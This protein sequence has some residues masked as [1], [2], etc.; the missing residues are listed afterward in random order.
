MFFKGVERYKDGKFSLALESF[1]KS[2]DIRPHWQ[3]HFNVGL[4][5][6]ELG[7]YVKAKR[8]FE[9]YL[10]KGKSRISKKM[11]K[12][13]AE[14]LAQIDKVIE[15]LTVSVN[16]AGAEI[17]VDGYA[18]GFSPLAS[19]VE[20]GRGEHVLEVVRDGYK[21]YR[22]TLFMEPGEAKTIDV[23]LTQIKGAAGE[24]QPA[25]GR[26][27]GETK[28]K[29]TLTWV[30]GVG[31]GLGVGLLGASLYTGIKTL[32]LKSEFDTVLDEYDPDSATWDEYESA[33]ARHDGLK[34]DGEL[35]GLLTTVFLCS[36]A[37]LTVASVV[38][39]IVDW[40]LAGKGERQTKTRPSGGAKVAIVPSL[41]LEKNGASAG[42]TLRY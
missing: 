11:K 28:K 3:V 29:R 15:E 34:Q 32:D 1:K 2:Y 4:C 10:S 9:A 19:A 20:L 23:F 36:G 7:F 17:I 5:Y 22:T 40:K 26:A 37:V 16:V 39:F 25:E 6:K 12:K 35:Y 38:L 14:V 13:I 8:E 41:V 24:T 30:A 42:I 21:R 31:L 18:V 33:K 27:A